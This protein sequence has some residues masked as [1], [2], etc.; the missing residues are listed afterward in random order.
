MNVISKD[1]VDKWTDKYKINNMK[2][3][4][5]LRSVVNPP[6]ARKLPRIRE[7]RM[8]TITPQ[9]LTQFCGSFSSSVSPYNEYKE[10]IK[11]STVTLLSQLNPTETQDVLKEKILASG[12]IGKICASKLMD[13]SGIENEW[14]ILGLTVCGKFL[15]ARC[16]V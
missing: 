8:H 7:P 3:T 5:S 14:L 15:E 1:E 10:S 12:D 6:K 11:K 9:A 13:Y 16:G 2:H 4:K